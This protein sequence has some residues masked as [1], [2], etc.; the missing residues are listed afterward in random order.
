MCPAICLCVLCVP[1]IMQDVKGIIQDAKT[2][3]PGDSPRVLQNDFVSFFVP[4]TMQDAK[5]TMQDMRA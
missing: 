3:R 5:G 2:L 1:G 4:G